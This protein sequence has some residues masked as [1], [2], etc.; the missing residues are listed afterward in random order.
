M[1]FLRRFSFKRCVSAVRWR[2]SISARRE[3]EALIALDCVVENLRR[4]SVRAS[5]N[6]PRV[7]PQL[8]DR[9]S[10]RDIREHRLDGYLRKNSA[11]A[12]KELCLFFLVYTGFTRL[13]FFVFFL[14]FRLYIQQGSYPRKLGDILR[15]NVSATSASSGV[16]LIASR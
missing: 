10:N 6:L 4:S 13:F 14:C 1:I 7:S 2:S 8:G 9:V 5:A 16:I 11:M 3:L 15:D 12:E